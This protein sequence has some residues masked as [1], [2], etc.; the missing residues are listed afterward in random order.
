MYSKKLIDDLLKRGGRPNVRSDLSSHCF[1]K[2]NSSIWT[3]TICCLLFFL[4]PLHTRLLNLCFNS[5]RTIPLLLADRIG[6]TTSKLCHKISSAEHAWQ[7]AKIEG[8]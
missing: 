2:P 1:L 4:P 8:P 5:S 7:Q 6:L 3:P